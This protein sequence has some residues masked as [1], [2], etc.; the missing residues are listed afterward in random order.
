M[1][2]TPITISK[3]TISILNNFADLNSNIMIKPGNV[4]RTVNVARTAMAE[5]KVSEKFEQE[6][7][8]WNLHELLGVVSLC[9]NPVFHFN[10]KKVN[11]HSS[12]G[13]TVEYFYAEPR[14]LTLPTKD[15][16]MPRFTAVARI[17]QSVFKEIRRIASVLK[18]DDISF[19]N[20]EDG[21]SAVVCDLEN[22]TGNKYTIGIGGSNNGHTFE[23]NL[24]I[25]NLI[26]LDGDY[27]INFS[28]NRMIVLQNE[29]ID[30]TYW[31]GVESS[32][33]YEE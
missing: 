18:V 2:K 27:Q 13:S 28:E 3:N 21:V 10:D 1:S 8:I 23:V 14:L 15:P 25:S 31:F 7:G 12:N 20:T 33:T 17:E 22:P 32:S 11:I 29:A 26:I 4:I 30:L 24:K 6:F 5:A 16:W 9:N 19:V